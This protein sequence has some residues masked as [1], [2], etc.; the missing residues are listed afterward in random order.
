MSY[1]LKFDVRCLPFQVTSIKNKI[2]NT[3]FIHRF[4]WEVYFN[5]F[6]SVYLAFQAT[7]HKPAWNTPGDFDVSTSK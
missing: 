7:T 5:I 6:F 3:E 4:H 1:L 2:K